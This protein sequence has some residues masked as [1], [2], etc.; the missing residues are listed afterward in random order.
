MQLSMK[1]FYIYIE[2]GFA[3]VFVAVLM[4]V[5]PENFEPTTTVYAHLDLPQHYL[6]SAEAAFSRDGYEIQMLSSREEVEAEL[7]GDRSSVGLVV[8][9]EGTR[10]VYD[11]ILQGYENEK[12]K[13]IIKASIE[14]RFAKTLP[15]FND[16]TSVTTIEGN[17]EKLSDRLNMLPVFLGLNA[18]FMGL[19]IIAA[20]IFLDKD[21]GTIK[22]F[23][24]TPAKV[25]HYLL[26][27]MGVMLVTGLLSGLIAT[28]FIAG[29][30]A[31][32]FH[33]IMLLI[34]LNA[35]GSALGLFISSFFDSMTKAMG[36][37]YVS[38]IVLAFAAVSYYMPA[39]SPL[40]IRILPSYP[41]LFAFRETLYEVVNLG[42][43]YANVLGFAA[44]AVVFFLLSNYRFKKTLTV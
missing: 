24:V 3:L 28:L 26:S 12:F 31:H 17:V 15:G 2:V 44:L 1:S 32:Y 37:L 29:G 18:A 42:Y 8:S 41:M 14:G 4:F 7:A 40:I 34:S 21:E 22:A 16:V 23:A 19:F 5:V 27:K 9:L 43:V 35:F 10:M 25:W 33:L 13:N 6:E 30:K 11:Y 20:Y 38:I 39:F 36:W